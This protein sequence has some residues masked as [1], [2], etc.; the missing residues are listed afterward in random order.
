VS[1]RTLI[2]AQDAFARHEV[3]TGHPE[4]PDRHAAVMA[5]LA[6]GELGEL[7]RRDCPS[8]SREALSRAHTDAYLARVEG[9]APSDG[10]VQMDADTWMGPS[11]LEAAS[12]GAGGAVAAVEAVMRGEA[13]RAFVAS[14]PPGHHAEREAA[15]GFCL[16]SN[17]GIAAL[18]ARDALGASRVAVLDFDV[19]H[20]NG[21]QDVLWDEPGALYASSHE[22]PL[23]PGTGKPSERGARGVVRNA[24]LAAGDD[25]TA[26]RR[27]WAEALLPEVDAFAPDLLILSAGFDAHAADPLANL[28]LTEKDFAWITAEIATLAARHA[29]G[30]IVSILEGGY[31]LG[32][33]GRSVAA[34]VAALSR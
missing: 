34:H 2:F 17:A 8:A 23:Y 4:R 15:M 19:H 29:G 26:F 1:A 7:E 27:V 22:W 24:T 32:A 25:G 9:S 14:R 11:S 6:E 18:H 10:L 3:P 12:R 16:Y 13:D 30:R 20:G 5:A 28:E 33:L 31:D 21:T